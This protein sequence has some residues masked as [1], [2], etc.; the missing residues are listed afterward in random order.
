MN[1]VLAFDFGASTGR[2]L[3]GHFDGEKIT[4]EEVHRF[5]NVPVKE[6]K[7]IAWD[8]FAL[9][10]D[11][12][13]TIAFYGKVDSLAFD[14]WGVDYG[15]LTE[16]D[17]LMSLPTN[18]RDPRTNGIPEKVFRQ[19]SPEKLYMSTGNQIMNINTLFQLMAEKGKRL[20]SKKMLF[21]PDLFAWALCG[22]HYI[23][24]NR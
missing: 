22:S 20:E 3:L 7:R 2:A 14:T 11:V 24:K 8:F 1:T 21:M 6:N 15:L 5:D 17:Y 19:I 18:Y 4:Y 23:H 13:N 10:R 9:L 16:H 12:E